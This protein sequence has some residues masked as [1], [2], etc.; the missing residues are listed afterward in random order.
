MASAA[1]E[2]ATARL[3]VYLV[4]LYERTVLLSLRKNTG[5]KDGMYRFAFE[6]KQKK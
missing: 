4:L 5:F 3:A 2:R 1:G 6:K